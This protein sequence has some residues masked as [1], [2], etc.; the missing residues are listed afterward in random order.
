MTDAVGEVPSTD[1]LG[2]V[3]ISVDPDELERLNPRV[4]LIWLL[5]VA[6]TAAILAMP[7]A[8]I[9]WYFDFPAVEIGLGVALFVVL[10]GVPYTVLRYRIWGFV[11][12]EDSLYLQRGVLVRVQTVVPYVRIQHVDTSRSPIE[13]MSSLA[14]SVIYT[15]GSRGADVSIPGL[16]PERARAL[17]ERLKDLANVA[18]QD[19]AV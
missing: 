6:I 3:D 17:Q 11:V 18:G 7:V 15:A 14:S 4:Q 1:E 13:R 16:E 2:D 10:L 5:G 8:A 9:A 19:D 12:R